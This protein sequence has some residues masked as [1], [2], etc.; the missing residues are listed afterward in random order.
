M[1]QDVHHTR[2]CQT[3]GTPVTDGPVGGY[4]CPQCYRVEEPL[5]ADLARKEWR[6]D[7]K[8]RIAAARDIWER[9]GLLSNE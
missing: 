1:A 9:E 5:L 3:C 4:V 7:K 6:R 8:S 2:Y